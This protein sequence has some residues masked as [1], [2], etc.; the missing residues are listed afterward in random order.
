MGFFMLYLYWLEL[1]NK[2]WYYYGREM[3]FEFWEICLF[4]VILLGI[5]F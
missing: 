1:R 5:L 2:E 3:D 4:V